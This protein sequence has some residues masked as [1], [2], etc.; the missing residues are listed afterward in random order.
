MPTYRK[1]TTRKRP[2]TQTQRLAREQRIIKDLKAGKL[3]YRKIA[4]KH[5]VSLPTVNAKSR[6]A[7]ISRSRRGPAA[8]LK[9]TRAK[10]RTTTKRTT[11]AKRTSVKT[12]RARKTVARKKTT[13]R[14]KSTPKVVARTAVRRTAP[15]SAR[16]NEQL[17]WLVM[18]YYPNMP[19]K[20]FEKLTTTI[21]KAIS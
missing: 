20:K 15:R 5:S 3:S 13:T 7:G 1:K 11:L 2:L 19:L 16:F 10:A 6:K 8:T 18:N 17:R 14:R 12:T 21:A 9:T 4:V